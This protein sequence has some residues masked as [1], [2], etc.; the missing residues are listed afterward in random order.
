RESSAEAAPLPFFA[1]IE[2]RACVISVDPAAAEHVVAVVEDGRLPGCNRAL[3]LV[4]DD[5][6]APVLERLQHRAAGVVAM[7]D[8]H[9]H[10]LPELRRGEP[11]HARRGERLAREAILLAYD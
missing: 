5:A 11:V 4:E 10:R 7:A 1:T 3:R 6:H 8:L 2:I 9:A